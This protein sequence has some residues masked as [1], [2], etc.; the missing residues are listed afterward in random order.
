MSNPRYVGMTDVTYDLVVTHVIL[1]AHSPNPTAAS[2]SVLV[3]H[4]A[5]Y[6]RISE[7][8]SIRLNMTL[9]PDTLIVSNLTYELSSGV[10]FSIPFPAQPSL[11]VGDVVRGILHKGYEKYHYGP[12]LLEC[13]YYVYVLMDYFKE[14]SW[15]GGTGRETWDAVSQTYDH[16]G[17]RMAETPEM[18]QGTFYT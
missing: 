1:A 12:L 5:V 13:R 9:M 7:R 16:R 4:W 3:N 10:V 11:T 2:G 17:N 6:L 14:Q 15:I 18:T 8:Q